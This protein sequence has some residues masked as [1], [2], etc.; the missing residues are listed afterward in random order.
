M[1]GCS[2]CGGRVGGEGDH[3]YCEDCGQTWTWQDDGSVRVRAGWREGGR[4]R[5]SSGSSS[6]E[7][8]WVATASYGDYDSPAVVTLRAFRDTVL[9][10]TTLGMRATDVYY[11]VGPHLAAAI[12]GRPHA[13]AASRM[14]LRPL[15]AYA[16]R[17]LD[18]LP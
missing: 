3:S 12:R 7:D 15:V 2:N 6:E 18:R 13:C 14:L 5:G 11:R 1:A 10:T 16:Q 17:R 8:C 9:A 4:G